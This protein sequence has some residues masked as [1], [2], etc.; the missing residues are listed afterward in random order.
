MDFPDYDLRKLI[1][2]NSESNFDHDHLIT[3]VYNL[4]CAVNYL[5]ST[6]IILTNLRA[7]NVAID[8]Q[9][10]VKI[11]NLGGAQYYD[12]AQSDGASSLTNMDT[13]ESTPLPLIFNKTIDDESLKKKKTKVSQG[14][15]S[16][17]SV[18]VQIVEEEKAVTQWDNAPEV[19]LQEK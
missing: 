14:T 1:E 10:F 13:A 4:L 17:S 5:H 19:V 15:K 16:N 9:C 8:E 7:Q 12:D 18:I 11:H 2:N 3:I 6:N